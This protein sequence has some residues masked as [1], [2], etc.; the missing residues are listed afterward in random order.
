MSAPHRR[1]GPSSFAQ[2]G[3]PLTADCERLFRPDLL[4][5]TRTGRVGA[6][7]TVPTREQSALDDARYTQC[8][9]RAIEPFVTVLRQCHVHLAVV[10]SCVRVT[11]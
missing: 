4:T 11:I 7:K 1:A 6:S 9:R 3:V 8:A 10:V 5:C 2:L